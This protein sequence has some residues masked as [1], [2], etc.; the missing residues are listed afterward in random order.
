[1][2][3][4]KSKNEYIRAM[5][6]LTKLFYYLRIIR[7]IDYLPK[8][9]TGELQC[10]K[11]ENEYYQVISKNNYVAYYKWNWFNPLT[12]VVNII[13]F[14]CIAL[15][16]LFMAIADVFASNNTFEVKIPVD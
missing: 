13:L 1:M 11:E 12:Y 10:T 2:S 5:R 4:W 8:P 7:H 16:H 14:V 6:P 9:S 3:T 15:G